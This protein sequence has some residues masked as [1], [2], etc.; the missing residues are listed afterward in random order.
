MTRVNMDFT[1]DVCY[2]GLFFLADSLN[3][4]ERRVKSIW[5]LVEQIYP[6]LSQLPDAARESWFL[7]LMVAYSDG[8]FNA[9]L[10]YVFANNPTTLLM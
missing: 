10:P 1:Q 9:A 5:R 7:R 3:E 6:A 8:A 2:Q 4:G